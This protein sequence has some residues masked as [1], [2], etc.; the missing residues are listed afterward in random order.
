MARQLQQASMDGQSDVQ[1]M[2]DRLDAMKLGIK[3][4]LVSLKLERRHRLRSKLL[5]ADPSRKK[6]WRFLKNQIRSAGNITASYDSTGKMVFQQD[7][8]EDAVISHFSSIF[9]AFSILE[10]SL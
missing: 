8:I 5:L 6:F 9:D 3:D 10:N 7:E 4:D 2:R 1:A